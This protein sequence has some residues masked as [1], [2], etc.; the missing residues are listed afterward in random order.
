MPT[1]IRY[2]DLEM[3][4][5]WASSGAPFENRA[6]VSRETDKLFTQ[7]LGGD[8]AGEAP[9]DLDDGGLYIEVP[10]KNELDLGRQLVFRFVEDSA[11]ILA[12]DVHSIFRHRGAYAQ[13]KNLLDRTDL[14]ERWFEYESGA[15]RT[16]LMVWAKEH[17]FEVTHDDSAG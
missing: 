15:M 8:F 10:H 14:L 4:L 6:F 11:P 13:F 5:H 12:Q 2:D 9:D 17:G 3:A 7:L 16:A 1:P